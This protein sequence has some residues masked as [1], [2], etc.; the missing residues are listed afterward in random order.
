M[1]CLFDTNSHVFDLDAAI[2]YQ[3]MSTP[4]RRRYWDA[5]R[6]HLTPDGYDLMGEKIAAALVEL[7]MPPGRLQPS[8]A[9][10]PAKKRRK[11]FRDDD[12][13][14]DEEDGDERSLDQGWIV[15]RRT[16]LQ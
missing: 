1:T 12:K 5:D 9:A 16:D 6:C 15:V 14:F 4:E 10:R 8:A 7:I 13:S 11:N 3:S 2:P